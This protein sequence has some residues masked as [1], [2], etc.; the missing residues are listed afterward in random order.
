[1]T[2]EASL[3][4]QFMT[5]VPLADVADAFR[6]AGLDAHYHKNPQGHEEVFV[7]GAGDAD[8]LL[9]P[10]TPSE[11]L[12]AD[13]G[14]ERGPLE[15]MARAMSTVL[16]G[17]RIIHRLELYNVDDGEMFAYLHYGWPLS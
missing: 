9:E 10:D 1:M 3:A 2:N 4:G 14:G 13:A 16:T 15:E 12:V 7:N 6:R 11:Y 17:M 5:D 8:C